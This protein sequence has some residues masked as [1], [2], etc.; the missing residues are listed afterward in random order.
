MIARAYFDGV[1][2]VK[3]VQAGQYTAGEAVKIGAIAPYNGI[4]PPATAR[5]SR[6]GPLFVGT[7]PDI[8]ADL[9]FKLGGHWTASHPGGIC[10]KNTYNTI[11]PARVDT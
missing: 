8:F 11:D 1:H 7:F 2:L 3:H 10:F 5:P 6:G 4:E 9:I